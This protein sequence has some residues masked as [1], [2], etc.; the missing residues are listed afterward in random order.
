MSLIESTKKECEKIPV[1]TLMKGLQNFDVF[2]DMNYLIHE[3]FWS[4]FI[5]ELHFRDYIGLAC[6]ISFFPSGLKVSH[7]P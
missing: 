1:E 2:H 6:Q 5:F 3:I 7:F 4:M